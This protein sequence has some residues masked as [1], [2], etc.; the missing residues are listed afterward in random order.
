[1]AQLPEHLLWYA[2]LAL[3]PFGLAAGIRRDSLVTCLLAGYCVPTACLGF[4][5]IIQR[6]V[7][8]GPVATGTALREA[9]EH[10]S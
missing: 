8:A 7:A 10:A 4:C 1:M 6:F 3:A 5:A 9:P 2:L